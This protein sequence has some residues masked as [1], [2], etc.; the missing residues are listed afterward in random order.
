MYRMY[1]SSKGLQRGFKGASKG[2]RRG[3]EGPWKVFYIN[4]NIKYLIKGVFNRG[5][6]GG[7][8]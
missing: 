3:L 6:I 1:L 8:Y 4:I 2:L 7:G 5:V